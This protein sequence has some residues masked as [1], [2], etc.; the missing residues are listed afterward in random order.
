MDAVISPSKTQ[1]MMGGHG[2]AVASAKL[3]VVP[4][5]HI[6]E[7]SVLKAWWGQ[8]A[9]DMLGRLLENVDHN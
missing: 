2:V 6:K 5:P 7:N 8:H 9:L 4:I 1:G 3:W